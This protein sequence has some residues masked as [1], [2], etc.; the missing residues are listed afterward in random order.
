MKQRKGTVLV[1][2]VIHLNNE[3]GRI[4]MA[5]NKISEKGAVLSTAAG[6]V[7]GAIAA[8]SGVAAGAGA[9]TAGGAAMTSGLAAVGTIIGGGMAAGIIV[10]VAAPLAGCALGYLGFR[11]YKKMA[12]PQKSG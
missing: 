3:K 10:I 1:A 4:K 12:S 8:V 7:T 5:E 6:G 11:L 9:G 2:N